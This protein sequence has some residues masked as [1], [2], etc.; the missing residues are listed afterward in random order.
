MN[1]QTIDYLHQSLKASHVVGGELRIQ[2]FESE[3]YQELFNV[4]LEQLAPLTTNFHGN[5]DFWYAAQ[6]K[7]CH[8]HKVASRRTYDFYDPMIEI[9]P[10]YHTIGQRLALLKW[11]ISR[12]KWSGYGDKG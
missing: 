5:F 6:C 11:Y 8:R 3:D 12:R 10:E 2:G 7:K 9:E 1:V 4:L